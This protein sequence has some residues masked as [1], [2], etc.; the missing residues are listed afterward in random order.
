MYY[1][2]F[3]I[4]FGRE[5]LLISTLAETWFSRILFSLLHRNSI[6][7][8]IHSSLSD[9][10]A[11][12]ELGVTEKLPC[13]LREIRLTLLLCFPLSLMAAMQ[14]RWQGILGYRANAIL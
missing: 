13:V 7:T 8:G 12:L 2:V 10:P 6:S 5:K 3:V 4:Y 1:P 14:I 11:S 9:L